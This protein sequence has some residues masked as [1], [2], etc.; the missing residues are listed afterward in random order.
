MIFLYRGDFLKNGMMNAF[1]ILGEWLY[2]FL[3]LQLYWFIGVILGG[4]ILGI[5]PS[6]YA[7]FAVVRKHLLQSDMNINKVFWGNYQAVFLKSQLKGWTWSL[8]GMFIYYDIRL[9]FAYQNLV[10]FVLASLFVTMLMI[11]GLCSMVL[12][13][14]YS[15]FNLTV[16][17]RVRL[18]LMI[19]I[20]MPHISVG[21]TVGT[22]I[23]YF[24][25]TKTPI[26]FMLIGIGV[27]A[28][29]YT[30]LSSLAFQ[31]IEEKSIL[32]QEN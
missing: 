26:L 23:V 20:T 18:A 32:Y 7:A 13:P 28:L 31:K 8:I 27:I 11:Y 16:L 4:V 5:F 12:L 24:I 2:F 3:I 6:T 10:G 9:L 17:N 19:V 14:I 21:L 15:H 30:Y 25:A 29:L 1:T 22:V